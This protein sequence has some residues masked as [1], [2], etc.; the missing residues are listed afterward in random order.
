MTAPESPVRVAGAW[1]AVASLLMLASLV[2]HG[3]I[4]PDLT[5]QMARIAGSEL[6]WSIVH[7]VAAA[8]LSLYAVAG[9]IML[10]SRSRLT[11][12]GWTITAWAVLSVSALWTV[13]TAVAEATVVANA[14]ISGSTETFEAWW[15]FAE[16]KGAG[17]SFLALAVAVIAGHEVRSADRAV[18]AWAAGIAVVAGIASFTGWALGIWIGIGFGTLL[19]VASSILMT[20]WTLWLGVALTSE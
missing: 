7:W 3:P 11:R 5:D 16:G 8:G 6:R 4:A 12:T 17:F 15:A 14:A 9:L 2:F 13:T 10:T 20:L 1:L 18:P 19:W